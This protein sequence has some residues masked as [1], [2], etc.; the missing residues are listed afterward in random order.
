MSMEI[1]HQNIG[2]QP[3][4]EQIF[5]LF[6][7]CALNAGY[8]LSSHRGL[9]I[10]VHSLLTIFLWDCRLI[11]ISPDQQDGALSPDPHCGKII[12][13]SRA[14]REVYVEIRKKRYNR[15]EAQMNLEVMTAKAGSE[16][17][18]V[19]DAE[20]FLTDVVLLNLW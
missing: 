19:E 8:R 16:Y 2:A 7:D 4:V 1:Q 12:V 20:S 5:Q 18:I 9:F 11:K 17:L 6:L 3:S 13:C 10:T 14:H 15:S